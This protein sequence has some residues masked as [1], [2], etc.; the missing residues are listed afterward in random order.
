MNN[1]FITGLEAI[2]YVNKDGRN[3]QGM[4]LYIMSDCFCDDKGFAFNEFF[5]NSNNGLYSKLINLDFD[6]NIYSC[7]VNFSFSKGRINIKSISDITEL[8]LL[9]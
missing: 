2:N 3:I 7:N 6:N 1:Y 4:K 5:I 8:P 9:Q